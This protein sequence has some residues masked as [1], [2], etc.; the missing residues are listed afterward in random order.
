[1]KKVQEVKEGLPQKGIAEEL[2]REKS[3]HYFKTLLGLTLR[4]DSHKIDT[5]E[6]LA[7]YGIDS[8]LIVQINHSLREVFG[9]INNSLLFEVQTIDALVKYFIKT[10]KDALIKILRL[11][12]QTVDEEDSRPH[13][14]KT[15][16]TPVI[17]KSRSRNGRRF[18]AWSASETEDKAGIS[19][20]PIAI[21][22][23]SGRYPQAKNLEAYWENLKSGRDCI[24]EIP[25]ERW[26][27]E[28]FF[29]PHVEEAVTQ[30]KSYS[31]W[32]GFLDGFADF[33]PLFFNISPREAVSMDPQERLFLQ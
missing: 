7:N 8:I 5:S 6:P 15:E 21:I 32:G 13:K 2:L 28:G 30:G 33:D 1:M 18:A 14:V 25:K 29:H 23:M 17:S 11:D 9:E 19:K 3:T 26:P 20:D 16:K 4:M 12:K 10:H 22:G 27:L 31:K 24:V